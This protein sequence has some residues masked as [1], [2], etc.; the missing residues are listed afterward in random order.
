MFYKGAKLNH[1]LNCM[2]ENTPPITSCDFFIPDWR[3]KFYKIVCRKKRRDEL[4]TRL[5]RI[6]ELLRALTNDR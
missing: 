4:I 2:R 5:D 6:E 1:C 3:K